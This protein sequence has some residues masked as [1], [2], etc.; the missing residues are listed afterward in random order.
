MRM[1]SRTISS[2]VMFIGPVPIFLIVKSYVMSVRQ[3]SSVPVLS[4]QDSSKSPPNLSFKFNSVSPDG[5]NVTTCRTVPSSVRVQVSKEGRPARSSI[6]KR[7]LA[8]TSRGGRMTTPSGV[9]QV[10]VMGWPVS[11]PSKSSQ[12]E[13]SPCVSDPS[14][15]RQST[16]RNSSVVILFPAEHSP[17][18][19]SSSIQSTPSSDSQVMS[20][21]TRHPT[22][23]SK[24]NS[25]S[26]IQTS[27]FGGSASPR[28]VVT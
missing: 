26:S 20:T 13:I 27:P 24:T 6:T 18:A 5:S 7:E 14:S 19:C 2:N 9:A 12:V 10:T 16:Y 21:S 3:S 15:Q 28:R 4:I 8:S 11:P 25:S 22:V 1:S 17:S 23:I